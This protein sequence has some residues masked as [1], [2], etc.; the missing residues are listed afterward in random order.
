MT[1]VS[2]RRPPQRCWSAAGFE[3]EIATTH[4]AVGDLIDATQSPFVL[5]RLALDG[6]RIT[7]NVSGV[8]SSPGAVTLRHL[9]SETDELR[10]GIALVVIA[11]RRRG[12]V[13]AAG[14]AGI[15]GAGSAR[16]GG[17]RRAIAEDAARC[18]I[19]RRPSRCDG[20]RGYATVMAMFRSNTGS[21]A[22]GIGLAALVGLVVVAL[23]V[24]TGGTG[25]RALDGEVQI[26]E[27]QLAKFDRELHASMAGATRTQAKGDA[28]LCLELARRLDVA[29]GHPVVLT[30]QAG[31]VIGE[32]SL[33]PAELATE[34]PSGAGD[35]VIVC[36]LPF[37]VDD[38]RPTGA[39]TIAI[40]DAA[41]SDIPRRRARSTKLARGVAARVVAAPATQHAG[42]LPA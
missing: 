5:Q 26:V 29:P 25:A 6:V 12:L 35:D 34:G 18:R 31:S 15:G 1:A 41:T 9:Y 42:M 2:S 16:R 30:D 3:V 17:R 4:P 36:R 24:L 11:G 14:R 38:I 32:S 19:G 39:V 13:T 27:S 8:A 10:E 22:V 28:G 23:V 20:G 7:P 33:G 37:R 40:G 21:F